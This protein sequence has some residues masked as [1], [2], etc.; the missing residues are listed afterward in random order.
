MSRAKELLKNMNEIDPGVANRIDKKVRA[1]LDWFVDEVLGVA[2]DLIESE[3]DKIVAV[4]EFLE[5]LG[6][7]IRAKLEG[8]TA[9]EKELKDAY[10][11]AVKN[12]SEYKKYVVPLADK[13]LK[14]HSR[15][16]ARYVVFEI[17]DGLKGQ[18]GKGI[19]DVIDNTNIAVEKR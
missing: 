9:K 5:Y 3:D 10:N 6:A 16:A 15:G 19:D 8:Q 18:K 17:I 1:D 14:K 12:S 2:Q 13:L 7:F 4:A 11:V